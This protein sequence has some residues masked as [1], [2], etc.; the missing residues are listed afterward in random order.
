MNQA[1][2]PTV[3]ALGSWKQGVQVF[4]ASFGYRMSFGIAWAILDLVSKQANGL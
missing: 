4:R 3:L 2:W 1:W